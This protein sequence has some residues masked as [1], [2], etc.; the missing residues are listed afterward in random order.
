MKEVNLEKQELQK[1][2]VN[3]YGVNCGQVRYEC[4]TDCIMATCFLSCDQ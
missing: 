2:E 3:T 4:I 1:E